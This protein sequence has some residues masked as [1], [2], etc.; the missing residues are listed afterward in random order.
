MANSDKDI[1]I[2]PNKGTANI[3]E[4][5]FVGQVNSPIKL[6]VL[7]DNTLSFEGSSGQLFSINNNLTSGTIF[8][9]SDVS[10]V[11]GLAFDANGSLRLSP[12]SGG[13]AVGGNG[14]FTPTA[15]LH[16]RSSSTGDGAGPIYLERTALNQECAINWLTSGVRKWWLG[17]DNDSTDNFLGIYKW[18][19]TGLGYVFSLVDN[20]LAINGRTPTARLNV[21]GDHNT[22]QLRLTLPAA[23][24]G[25]GAGIAHLQAWLSEPGIT[26][27]G[28]GIGV[29]VTNYYRGVNGSDANI[30]TFLNGYTNVNNDT[31]FPRFNT[32]LGQAYIRMYPGS[33]SD[34]FAFIDFVTSVRSGTLWPTT[35]RVRN[36]CV[37]MGGVD[38]NSAYR[39]NVN[40]NI[41]FVG[42]LYKNGV[43]YESLPAQSTTTRGA[44]LRSNGTAAYWDND[45]ADTFTGSAI[46]RGYTM[47]GYQNGVGWFNVNRTDHASDTTYNLGDQVSTIDAY[48]AAC[49]NGTYAYVLHPG[50][51]W[52]ASGREINRF[53]MLTDTNADIATQM[54]TGKDRTSIMRSKFV[55]AYS[56][57]EGQ[58][59][60]FNIL[61]ETPSLFLSSA[62]QNG[63]NAGNPACGQGELRGWHMA[64]GTRGNYLEF[65]T[66]TWNSW[67]PPGPDGT[68]KTISTYT[69]FAYWNTGGGYATGNAWSKRHD[70]NGSQYLTIGK[71]GVTGEESLH[72][73]ELK[74]YMVGMYNGAQN[75]Q[76]GIMNYANN[77]FTFVTSV[78]SVGVGG[79]ASAAGMEYGRGV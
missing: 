35:M 31:Y 15:K 79:R 25:S 14:F 71:P 67:A 23:N 4:I 16:V 34:D 70:Y 61:T 24:N 2:T 74:G 1:L 11:P 56:F 52:T 43:L 57:G 29:N 28:G 27:N 72:T 9:V 19:G 40:G 54:I 32:N 44:V 22:T 8:A 69:G 10:G 73:G 36:G 39:L 21:Y 42:D 75:N 41:N 30:G 53:N 6:R 76:G 60:K 33:G 66:E 5:N 65:T 68:N 45:T 55:H 51:N 20:N 47:G 49:S 64:P 37:A 62:D 17:T 50:G 38:I 7:D 48:C 12:F 3:P 26:W 58:P 78:N 59:E 13:V 63:S 18:D 77:T 46:V